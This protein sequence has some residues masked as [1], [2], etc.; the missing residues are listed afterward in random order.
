MARSP[1]PGTPE[2]RL[3]TTTGALQELCGRLREETF[4]T[5]DT[6][7]M[8]ERTYWPELCVVQLGGSQE[9]AV[10]DALA[11][12]LD[13]AALGDAPR[14]QRSRKVF[15]AARQDVEIFVLKF[16]RVPRPL[17][18]T[19]IGAMVAGFGDQVG[20]DALVSSLTG[21]SIDKAHRFSDW[22]ARPLSPAQIAYAA[23]D[24]TWLRRVYEKPAPGSSATADRM[25]RGGNGGRDRS[26]D[27]SRRSRGDV[28]AARPR[29][30]NRRFLGML[31]AVA[32]WREREAQRV[33][34]PRQRLLKDETLLEI[35]ATAPGTPEALA[36]ARGVTRGFAEGKTGASLIAAIRLA[37]ALPDEALPEA[38]RGRD[39]PRPSPALVS[40]LKVLLAA[41]CEQH[42]VAPKLVAELRRDR[43]PGDGG[44][45]R[46]PRPARMAAGRVRRRR[47]GAQGRARG[48][49]RRGKA[50]EAVAGVRGRRSGSRRSGS[51]LPG[52]GPRAA[53][54]LPGVC[55]RI[56]AIKG[57]RRMAEAAQASASR[58]GRPAAAA[59][60]VSALGIVYGDIG[61]SPLYALKQAADAGGVPVPHT[62]VGVVSLDLLGADRHRV[63]EIRDPD[64][65]RR[66]PRRGRHRG[67]ARAAGRA[68]R[69]GRELARLPAGRRPDRGGA[70]LRRRRHHAGHLGA[71]RGRGIEAGRA[72][73]DAGGRAHHGRHPDR[74]VPH[75]APGDGVHRLHLRPG[76]ARMVR[77]HRRARHRSASCVT[78]PCSPRSIRSAPSNICSTPDPAI[79][80]RGAR[81]R[82]PGRHG[83]RGDVCGYGPF[84]PA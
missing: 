12:G 10:V 40:L 27:L 59:L 57:G 39:G 22:S 30:A 44:R 49:R 19:Q 64:S 72:A 6:E 17:F 7:F 13:L 48:A 9:V 82:L 75:S 53:F 55:A 71:Q 32:A 73:A 36:R 35:A 51:L 45:A 3:I 43:A 46:H 21:G 74:P 60:T 61:T 69:A 4:V 26:C 41:K 70:A 66:Q 65:A 5:V 63:P 84:R 1:R 42:H 80:F 34:I 56:C 77:G 33:N 38:P 2:P 62:T 81:G 31:Q 8:R 23:A 76:D 54:P 67:H 47:A 24:V 37:R 58:H 25:G 15:H 20:Y 14:R 52:Q 11:P 50:G 18:D 16:G 28:G 83:R 78:P 68:P 79:S 29:T